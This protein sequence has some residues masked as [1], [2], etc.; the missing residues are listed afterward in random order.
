MDGVWMMEWKAEREGARSTFQV[1]KWEN[2]RRVDTRRTLTGL[3]CIAAR[4]IA[5]ELNSAYDAGWDAGRKDLADMFMA[6]LGD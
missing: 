4:V 2:G 3:S 5:A 1:V 6:P